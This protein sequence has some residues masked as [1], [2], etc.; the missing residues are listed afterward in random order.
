MQMPPSTTPASAGELTVYVVTYGPGDQPWEKFG[1]NMLVIGGSRGGVAYNWG[2]FEFDQGFVGRFMQGKLMY[3]MGAD[4]ADDVMRFYIDK[5]DRTTWVQQLNLN[6][7]QK[8]AL[9]EFCRRNELPENR[10]YR[11][12]YFIDNCSTRVR[13]AI[14][15][16]LVG[17]I[18]RQAT[19]K[20]SDRTFRS[21][22][23]RLTAGDWWLYTALDFVLGHPT[24]ERM[25]AWDEMFVPM[26]MHDRL[27]E[28]TIT[29][30]TGRQVPLVRSDTLVHTSKRPPPRQAQ[31]N[32]VWAFGAVGVVLGTVMG[33]G[34]CACAFR[35]GPPACGLAETSAGAK[36]AAKPQAARPVWLTGAFGLVAI[37]WALLAGF[38]GSMLVYFWLLTDH[39]AVRPNEN[40]LQLSPLV[41]PIIVLVPLLLRGSQRAG[42]IS[43]VLAGIVL[44]GSVLGLLLKVLPA[45][46]QPNWNIIALALPANAG[47]AWAMWRFDRLL[48]GKGPTA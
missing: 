44:A 25:T 40:I 36:P 32:W 28:M 46:D 14:D 9:W 5:L 39:A 3:W 2:M 47:L 19:T 38:G 13:D 31:P 45:M 17:Q 34:G 7:A 33:R 12:D 30:E 35:S 23:C 15:Q 22:T 10:T 37:S 8:Q 41:L 1:H 42:R 24:D 18:R 48:A 43:L 20:P 29:G 27:N 21:E 16:A 11:Y 4:P 26:L 6:D